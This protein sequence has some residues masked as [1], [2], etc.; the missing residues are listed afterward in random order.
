M[1]RNRVVPALKDSPR[2]PLRRRPQ[3]LIQRVSSPLSLFLSDCGRQG[4]LRV[5]ARGRRGAVLRHHL[6]GARRVGRRHAA[7]GQGRQTLR[8]EE[9]VQGGEF[10]LGSHL[11]TK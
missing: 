3:A 6:L 11:R 9:D 2:K 10:K 5:Q 8:P 1:T 7:E 4:A